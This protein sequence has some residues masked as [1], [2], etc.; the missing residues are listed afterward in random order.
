MNQEKLSELY[1]KL[2]HEYEAASVALINETKIN[3]NV[4]LRK[5]ESEISK[6]KVEWVWALNDEV[7][8]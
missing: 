2:L 5:L 3:Y 8:E 6:W 7:E 4:E 1:I